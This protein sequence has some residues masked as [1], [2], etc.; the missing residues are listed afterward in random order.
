MLCVDPNHTIKAGPMCRGL[1]V[2]DCAVTPARMC[3]VIY[4]HSSGSTLASTLEDDRDPSPTL[5]THIYL[6]VPIMLSCH[7]LLSI[8]WSSSLH[9]IGFSPNAMRSSLSFA[10]CFS[11]SSRKACLLLKPLLNHCLMP[12]QIVN[13]YLPDLKLDIHTHNAVRTKDM[14]SL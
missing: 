14:S 13:T 3:T 5:S 11:F 7:S 10:N 8:S 9:F 12:A 1:V 2:K 6:A 4:I